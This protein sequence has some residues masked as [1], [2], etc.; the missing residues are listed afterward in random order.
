MLMAGSLFV[1]GLLATIGFVWL[2]I[3]DPDRTGKA[4]GWYGINAMVMAGGA[5]ITIG[6]PGVHAGAEAAGWLGAIGVS[7]LMAG[8]MIAYL[9]VQGIEM[10]NHG[11]PRQAVPVTFVALPC[12]AA[13]MALTAF[14]SL[15]LDAVPRILPIALLIS[16]ALGTLTLLPNL[17]SRANS[18]L[19]VLY[20]ATFAA[21][22]L[23]LLGSL[24][25]G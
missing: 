20:T 4:A 7:V 22:G 24:T 21:W 6:L 12:L 15:R 2:G 11:L 3:V 17:S 9:A 5:L 8:M 23:W 10:V 18:F 16:L 19:P 13:G 1:G 14:V 25:A